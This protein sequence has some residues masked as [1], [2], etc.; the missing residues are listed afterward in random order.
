MIGSIDGDVSS[1]ATMSQ[2][3]LGFSHSKERFQHDMEM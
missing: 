2:K 1:G 3:V